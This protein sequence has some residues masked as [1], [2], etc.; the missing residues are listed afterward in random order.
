MITLAGIG[1]G[2]N[3]PLLLRL[4]AREPVEVVPFDARELVLPHADV[5]VSREAASAQLVHAVAGRDLRR[6]QV[7]AGDAAIRK[8]AIA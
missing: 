4:V 3:P 2:V 6:P 5:R 1:G 7:E 8:V